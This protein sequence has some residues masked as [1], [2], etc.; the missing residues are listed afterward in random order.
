MTGS[1]VTPPGEDGGTGPTR[2][3]AP[4]NTRPAETAPASGAADGGPA[5]GSTSATGDAAGVGDTAPVSAGSAGGVGPAAPGRSAGRDSLTTPIAGV[6]GPG[7]V[8]RSSL[9]WLLPVL[10]FLGGLVIGGGVIAAADLGSSDQPAAAAPTPGATPGGT[11]SGSGA[12]TITIPAACA[13]GLDRADTA[14]QAARDGLAGIT[15]LDP[16]AVRQAL[17][18][19]QTL[20]P[21]IRDLAARCRVAVSTGN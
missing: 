1:T 20:Q 19:L 10:A 11:D 18:R 8:R 16:T 14:A 5:I 7:R 9:Y 21:Q 12:T 6:S 13:D 15:Q 3:S 17:E 2:K 4:E